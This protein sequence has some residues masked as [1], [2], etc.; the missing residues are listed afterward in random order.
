[1]IS[2]SLGHSL[3]RGRYL[4][5]GH[6]QISSGHNTVH[7]TLY[8]TAPPGRPIN[9]AF[10]NRTDSPLTHFSFLFHSQR[11]QNR[12]SSFLWLPASQSLSSVNAA[13]FGPSVM[14]SL[15]I[16][17]ARP[18]TPLGCLLPGIPFLSVF[19]LLHSSPSVPRLY[20]NVGIFP[21]LLRAVQTPHHDVVCVRVCVPFVSEI[22]NR[23]N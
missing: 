15:S 3:L 16:P 20:K 12:D 7:P 17:A 10:A 2:F 13:F 1:M 18:S 8:Y 9:S 11:G 23:R 4:S 19:S 14:C 22:Q 6:F 5:S 21:A